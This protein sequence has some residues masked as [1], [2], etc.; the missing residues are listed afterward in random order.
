[1]SAQLFR[2]IAPNLFDPPLGARPWADLNG[3]LVG[4]LASIPQ[5]LAYGLIIGSALGGTFS[6]VGVLVALYG[7][8]LV[9][10]IAVLFGGCPFLVAGPRAGT[11]LV[12]T[13]LISQLS[14][15]AALS[16]LANPA[17]VALSLSCIA[18]FVCGLLQLAFGVFRLGRLVN[19]VPLPVVAGF[20]NGSALLIVLSQIWAATGIAPQNSALAMLGH[21]NEIKPATVLLALGTI[22]AVRLLPRFT[23]RLPSGLLAVVGGT[24][25]YHLLASF[26]FGPALGGTLPPP[27]DF[28]LRYLGNE[29]VTALSAPLGSDL[30]RPIVLAA[31]SMAILATLDTLLATSATDGLTSHRSDG[32]RQLLAE[33]FG[34]ALA[35]LFSMSPG[36]G[37]LVR[38]QAAFRGGM[39]SAAAP[40]GIAAITLVVTVALSP[41]IGTLSQAVMAGLLIS[42]GIDLIDNWTLARM[43]RL[44]SHGTSP[45]AAYSDLLIVVVVVATT[46]LADLATA[47]GIGVLLSL[48]SFVI[49]MARSPIRRCYR[50]TALIPQIYDDIRRRNFIERHGRNIAVIELEGALFFGTATELE[51]RV[52]SLA[53]EGV[54]HVVLD[55]RRVKHIDATGARTLERINSKLLQRNGLLVVS[56]VDRER[57]QRQ[58]KWLGE[59]LRSNAG[60]RANWVKLS[61]LGTINILGE[62]RFQ[63]DT[64]AAVAFCESHLARDRT[65]GTE[66]SG[67]VGSHSP[68][69]RSLGRPILRR[70][71]GYWS[72]V[73]FAAGDVVFSQGSPPD[74]MFLVAS[75][76]VKV[77]IDIPGTDR[78]RKVQSLTVGSV[79]G[80]MAL[81]DPKQRSA[82]IIAAEPTTCY[83]MTSESF[84]RLKREQT[85]IAFRLITDVAMIFAERLRATNT[86]LAEM[87]A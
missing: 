69:I 34:N 30:I 23:R 86:M 6:S 44:L 53:S 62:S 68:L 82:S 24:A 81:I 25:I 17:P 37:S 22:T 58:E 3:A 28:S 10:L 29:A 18:V 15:S 46:L 51:T 43:R 47:V 87:E 59:E 61:Y 16:H 39:A 66:F 9:G 7:S 79:F 75:G 31:A 63:T 77:L 84:E 56:Y 76:C 8:V 48:L 67:L 4:S 65:D 35:G 12:F 71:R 83:W 70:L 60:A 74:G 80:E 78:K 73:T 57:R 5:T 64:D 14:H 54:V 40:I 21:L 38:T 2:R 32:G 19:Y 50:A 45:F 33:G 11:L 13:A 55:M 49:K 42:L 41:L 1:L 27:G 26:G 36:S 20:V 72:R 52:V 85:D